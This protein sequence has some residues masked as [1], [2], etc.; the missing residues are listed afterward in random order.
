MIKKK[1]LKFIYF[2]LRITKNPI[3]VAKAI[4]LKLT[5][6]FT[7]N[8][9]LVNSLTKKWVSE[10]LVELP[11]GKFILSRSITCYSIISPYYE[12]ETRKKI[13]EIL[14]NIDP[15]NDI[16]VDIGA[17]IG[18]YVVELSKYFNK[19]V[20]FEPNPYIFKLLKCNTILNN[21]ED[22][23]DL[24]NYA[25]SDRDSETYFKVN[26]FNDGTSKIVNGPGE[27]VIKIQC[28]KFDDFDIDLKKVKLILIDVEG[29]EYQVLKGMKNGLKELPKG[30]SIIL[31]I[32]D[33]DPN[34]DKV[35]E[36]L[37]ENGFENI[38]KIDEWNYIA[39]KK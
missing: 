24:Y 18:R 35:I 39:I 36:L 17:H 28:K 8:V 7:K 29:H 12:V 32:H 5:L 16:F 26:Y 21:I 23:V 22:K 6:R 11:Y 9:D 19:I 25:L 30:C 14:K 34:K 2:Y 13:Y 27:D 33:N 20:A 4:L 3:F 10:R 15:E 37:K 1:H 31:E 38:Y